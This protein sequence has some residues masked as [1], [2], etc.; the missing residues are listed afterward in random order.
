MPH[1]MVDN[2]SEDAIRHTFLI[3]FFIINCLGTEKMGSYPQDL[4]RWISI[5]PLHQCN[6]VTGLF[7]LPLHLLSICLLLLDNIF[8]KMY[9][10]LLPCYEI[11]EWKANLCFTSLHFVFWSFGLVFL[12]FSSRPMR[13]Q[14]KLKSFLLAVPSRTL[15]GLWSRASRGFTL[16]QTGFRAFKMR[17]ISQRQWQS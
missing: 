6:S 4:R 3:I 10:L 1:F 12:F 7:L 5:D 11:I 2:C 13:R 9:L 15:Q 16:M 14:K 8:Q 17:W